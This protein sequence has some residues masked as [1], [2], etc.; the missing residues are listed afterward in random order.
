MKSPNRLSKL[1]YGITRISLRH[2]RKDWIKS[3]ILVMICSIGVGTFHSIRLSNKAALLGFDWF[4]DSISG[5]S[6]LIIYPKAQ[7]L[8]IEVLS[9]LRARTGSLP[10][11]FF[12]LL[13]TTAIDMESIPEDGDTIKAKQFQLVGMDIPSLGNL[14]YLKPSERY[15]PPQKNQDK[16]LEN[17]ENLSEVFI[18]SPLAKKATL[19]IGDKIPVIINTT[20]IELLV[21]GILPENDFLPSPPSNLILTDITEI[22]RLT[23]N[24]Q[25]L[26]RIEI[27]IPESDDFLRTKELIKNLKSSLKPEPTDPWIL[28]DESTKKASAAQMTEGFRLNLSILSLLAL[29]VGVYL[30]FQSLEASVTR[31]RTEAAVLKS[32]GWNKGELIELW[33]I[34]AFI[35]GL[36]GSLVGIIIGLLLAQ[37]T[38]SGIS[39]TVNALYYSN[40]T[41]AAGFD[42]IEALIAISI[43]V[44]ACVIAAIIPAKSVAD[45]PAAHELSK[46]TTG[47]QSISIS[48][49]LPWGIFLFICGLICSSAPPWVSNLG[50]NIPVGGYMAALL[51]L[52]S[53]GM[54]FL[55]ILP[56]ISE[57]LIKLPKISSINFLVLGHLRRPT[58]HHFWAITCLISSTAMA[59]SMGIL[60]SSFESTITKWMNQILT[61]DVFIASA[62]ISNASSKNRIPIEVW[63]NIT[64]MPE[65]ESFELGRAEDIVLEGSQTMITGTPRALFKENNSAIWIS[66][67]STD[68][69]SNFFTQ[70]QTDFENIPG[71]VTETF[72]SRFSV[73]VGDSIIVP[74]PLQSIKVKIGGIFADYGSEAGSISIPHSSF[75]QVFQTEEVL[76]MAIK[77]KENEDPDK[78]ISKIRNLFPSVA[79]RLNVEIKKEALRIFH[80][81]FSVTY[82]LQ[83]IGILVALVGLSLSLTS[84]A[85]DRKPLIQTWKE[86]GL[87]S[88]MVQSVQ[89]K[90]SLIITA[91]G[92][93]GGIL[94]SFQL[95]WLL[96]Y[97]INK[98]SFGWT[99]N[100]YIPWPS[101]LF[102]FG[103]LIGMGVIVSKLLVN[104]S[105]YR[106][107]A[108][109]KSDF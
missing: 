33:L 99:L 26:D 57:K 104:K 23:N 11:H 34:E 42:L 17:P 46:S 13:E 63:Q 61:D 50:R 58:K 44:G 68:F 1:V 102:I 45:S 105:Y 39:Q 71:I 87:S 19:K 98:Q 86:L 103:A 93:L 101:I 85:V 5:Q 30:I 106:Y 94:L 14:T 31:R 76:N 108:Q 69:S 41:E 6:P 18:S 8:D 10:V 49:I 96:I 51:W 9:D 100:Y 28:M 67:P 2:W 88:K 55:A 52:T 21:R 80:Q 56:L 32:L 97:V 53:F 77:L 91:L 22:Q 54:I 29:I 38:V 47:S 27:A 15:E 82:A 40:T 48:K 60:I 12:P 79:V 7:K 90:E 73:N 43:G 75:T 72:A 64:E 16:T 24:Y 109:N 92:T 4:S 35:L 62:G 36:A 95:G 78:F 65:V 107:Q 25:F 20:E 70:N 84:L 83:I 81:T 74:T 66:K 59:C 89:F 37:V 3:L